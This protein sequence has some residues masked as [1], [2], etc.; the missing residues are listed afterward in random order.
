MPTV[1]KFIGPNAILVRK[2]KNKTLNNEG[3]IDPNTQH[4][5]SLM[6]TLYARGACFGPDKTDILKAEAERL[7]TEKTASQAYWEA[8][9]AKK[10]AELAIIRE[11]GR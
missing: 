5:L 8:Q 10:E 7:E 9:A 6:E 2:G 11:R 4:T 3:K 1:R